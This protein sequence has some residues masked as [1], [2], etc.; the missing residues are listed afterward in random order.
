MIQS[1]G[2]QADQIYVMD[3]VGIWSNM[4]KKRAYAPSGVG[5]AGVQRNGTPQRDSMIACIR[6]DG[7]KFP[8]FMIRHKS[9][10]T[11]QGKLHKNEFEE[12]MLRS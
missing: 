4:I 5:G 2:Y 10:R 12:L 9:Q 3:E 7:I 11:K 6:G 8:G 1:R